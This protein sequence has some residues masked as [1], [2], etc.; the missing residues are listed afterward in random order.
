MTTQRFTDPGDNRP[1][2]A[3]NGAKIVKWETTT[4]NNAQPHHS[5][6]PFAPTRTVTEWDEY[7]VGTE[8]TLSD[9]EFAAWQARYDAD[10]AKRGRGMRTDYTFGPQTHTLRVECDDGTTGRA[11]WTGEEWLWVAYGQSSHSRV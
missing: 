9:E 7:D 4:D 1:T 2:H 5:F 11:V 3:P 8:R 10:I 6:P